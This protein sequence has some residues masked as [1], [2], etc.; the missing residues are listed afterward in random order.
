MLGFTNVLVLQ[1][2]IQL[3]FNAAGHSHIRTVGEG[4]GFYFN[5]GRYIDIKWSRAA[6]KGYVYT[7]T[8]GTPLEL[9]IGKSFICLV[10]ATQTP[11]IS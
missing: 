10:S 3:S 1:T 8:D 11:T 6:D 2:D 4:N 7:H 9:G 5:G